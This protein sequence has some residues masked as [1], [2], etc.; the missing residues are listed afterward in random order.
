MI[1]SFATGAS[2]AEF[3]DY[4]EIPD[5]V[6]GDV[7][8]DGRISVR[9]S[10][11]VQKHLAKIITLS[12]LSLAHADVDGNGKVNIMDATWIQK[13]VAKMIDTFPVEE[14]VYS[15]DYRYT[16]SEDE[17]S[18]ELSEGYS[19]EIELTVEVEGFYEITATSDEESICFDVLSDDESYYWYS[20]SDGENQSVFAKLYP[21][22]YR[23]DVFSSNGEP[24]TAKFK[25]FLSDKEPPVTAEEM[26]QATELKAGDELRIDA[27]AGRYVYKVDMKNLERVGDNFILY[28]EDDGASAFMTVYTPDCYGVVDST[29]FESCGGAYVEISDDVYGDIY[30]VLMNVSEESADFTL[31]MDTYYGILEREAVEIKLNEAVKADTAGYDAEVLLRFTPKEDGYYSFNLYNESAWASVSLRITDIN[32]PGGAYLM[33]DNTLNDDR[34]FDVL[35]LDGGCTYYIQGSADYSEEDFFNLEIKPSDEAEYLL[36]Q[37]NH[38]KPENDNGYNPSETT[39]IRVGDTVKA[40]FEPAEDAAFV[41]EKYVL[42]AEEDCEIV[43]YSEDSADACLY[44]F[45]KNGD[46]I[47]MGDDIKTV[48][49]L[50]EDKVYMESFDFAV[51]GKMKKGEKVY[52]SLTSFAKEKDGFTFSIVNSSDYEP[53]K[54]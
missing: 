40:E 9:D 43:L 21:G 30:Y 48:L 25:A 17:I 3:R 16:A 37:E 26:E 33:I 28:S 1:T 53:L 23:V 18:V 32:N 29:R 35:K 42:V 31:R 24:L 14:E 27:G 15:P 13:Y 7:D 49:T 4:Y 2:A 10:T 54:W 11:A 8:T 5:F 39:E 38:K 45:N 41:T 50:D 34:A 12:E 52:L 46:T 36:A 19:V 44:I 6:Y 20:Q 51:L 47:H 22:V